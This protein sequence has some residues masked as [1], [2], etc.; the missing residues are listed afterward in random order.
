[1]LILLQKFNCFDPLK[2]Y[3]FPD[4]T[5]GE[6]TV[7]EHR[8]HCRAQCLLY[9]IQFNTIDFLYERVMVRNALFRRRVE[10]GTNLARFSG[11]L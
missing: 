10:K 7:Y 2:Y 8:G 3:L 1:M 11:Q 5:V 9:T 6:S 4:V